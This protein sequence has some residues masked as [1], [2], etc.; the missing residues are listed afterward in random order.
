MIPIED[1]TLR[2]IETAFNMNTDVPCNWFANKLIW[3]TNKVVQLPYHKEADSITVHH[4][5]ECIKTN[6][7]LPTYRS[8]FH[9][10]SRHYAV[11]STYF[12]INSPAYDFA[13]NRP[14][15]DSQQMELQHK[16]QRR[17]ENIIH[18]AFNCVLLSAFDC[19]FTNI[20]L[21][22]SVTLTLTLKWTKR[23][24]RNIN[25]VYMNFTS[26]LMRLW[27]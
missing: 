13:I 21:H 12:S 19:M 27:S 2:K 7:A 20:K 1:E 18:Q 22:L 23:D 9:L 24:M 14:Q 16:N 3:I 5:F 4:R 15:R 25:S 17:D 26:V 8:I 10:H 6:S 11:T